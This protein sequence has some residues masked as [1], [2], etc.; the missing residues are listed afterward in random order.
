MFPD[1]HF[2]SGFDSAYI[3]S[4]LKNRTIEHNPDLQVISW[5]E[6]RPNFVYVSAAHLVLTSQLLVLTQAPLAF[7]YQIDLIP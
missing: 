6:L 7:Y 2:I 1:Y 5:Q 4:S 3:S